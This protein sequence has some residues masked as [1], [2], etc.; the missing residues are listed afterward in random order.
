M[1]DKSRV[2]SDKS[3][4]P[5]KTSSATLVEGRSSAHDVAAFLEQVKSLSATRGRASRRGRLLF[6]MDAT[7]SRQATW[8]MALAIQGEMFAAVGAIGGLDVQ[9]L[10]FRG[11]GEARASRWVSDPEALA[12][13]MSAV[14][15]RGGA[16]QIGKALLHARKQAEAPGGLSAMVFVGDSMEEDAD[17]LCQLAGELGLLGVPV[18]VFQEGYDNTAERTFREIARLTRGAWCRFDQGA[19]AQLRELLMAVAVFAAGGVTALEDMS[20]AGHG[21][22]R[23]LLEKLGRP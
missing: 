6:A 2:M 22:P 20:K 13:L 8:D 1:S 21:G 12:R 15:C 11:F 9:L 5:Q 14:R 7:M 17:H 4:P 23:L 16:T 18:F 10:Y 19:A 3:R